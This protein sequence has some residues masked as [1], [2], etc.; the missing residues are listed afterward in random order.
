MDIIK[1]LSKDKNIVICRHDKGKGVVLLNRCDYIKKMENILTDVSK[2]QQVNDTPFIIA[3]KIEDRINRV[4][5]KMKENKIIAEDI[6][7]SLRCTGSSFGILYGLPKVHKGA[8]LP[9]RPILAAYNLPNFKL[10]KF[11]V[12][13]LSPLTTNSYTIQ[14][15]YNFSKE[16]VQSLDSHNYMVSYDIESLFT[17]IPL[18]E[19]IDI[20][21]KK[22]F[23]TSNTF[24]HGFNRK[25]FKELLELAIYDSHFLFND[26]LY[27]QIDGCAMGSPLGPILANIFMCSLESEFLESCPDSFK[28]SFYKRYVDD[29]FVTFQN[30]QQADNFLKFIN[31]RHPN[32]KF[33]MEVENNK[34]LPFL[35]ILVNRQE[36]INTS[37]Y[38]KKTYTGLGSSFYSFT[39]YK[40]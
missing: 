36:G 1:S 8:A 37:V 17:N 2:F 32:I 24:F 40:Y 27:K 3:N 22:L 15:S 10:A 19:T 20:I 29:T 31:S 4:L 6:Y 35:D 33:T 9:L 23:P 28:P 12:P 14:N 11:M 30:E 26:K 7:T 18:E 38:R 13:I 39:P 34:S 21:L 25:N 16:I 5:L